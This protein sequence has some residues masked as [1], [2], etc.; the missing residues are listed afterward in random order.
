[1]VRIGLIPDLFGFGI[2]GE[3]RVAKMAGSDFGENGGKLIWDK[4]VVKLAGRNS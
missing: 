3:D 1:M 2:V 4:I